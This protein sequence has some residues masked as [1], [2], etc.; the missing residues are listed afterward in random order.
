MFFTKKKR[1]VSKN[2]YVNTYLSLDIDGRAKFLSE[3]YLMGMTY[4]LYEMRNELV[5]MKLFSEAKLLDA[6]LIR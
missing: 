1:N 5:K 6:K 2:E 4:H 3:L